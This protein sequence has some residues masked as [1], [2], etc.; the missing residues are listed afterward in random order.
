MKPLIVIIT[1]CS[2]LVYIL[3]PATATRARTSEHTDRNH[4]YLPVGARYHLEKSPPNKPSILLTDE[5]E[6]KIAPTRKIYGGVKDKPHLGGFTEF[7]QSGVSSN[8]WNYLL[9]PIGVKS[10]IDVGCGRGYSTKYFMDNGAKVLCVEGSHDAVL[11]SMLP[12]D[13]IVEH[14]FTR[15]QWWPDETYDLAWGVEFLEHVGRH[16]MQN[17]LPIFHKSAL[18]FVTGS[19][20]GGWHHVE[21]TVLLTCF[22]L[23]YANR[24]SEQSILCTLENF[25]NM[26]A[27]S[28]TTVYI[29]VLL[30]N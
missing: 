27:Y 22:I 13:K 29:D 19:T 24:R 18:I 23:L 30:G 5:E 25:D 9:G 16:F 28:L 10:F 14:D 11:Q 1:T 21:V 3:A 26:N 12:A 17:Y 20:W 7:D 8:A 6:K 4:L 2:L 15:G